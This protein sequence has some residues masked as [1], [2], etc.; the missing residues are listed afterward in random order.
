MTLTHR[1]ALDPNDRQETLL[2]QHAGW[3]RFAWNWGVAE[4]QRAL[5]AGEKSAT[6]QYRLRPAFNRIKRRTAPWSEA[7]SQN[8]AK[9]ALIDLEGAW[10]RFWREC[11]EAKRAGRR[12]RRQ[13]RPPRFHSRKRGM[14][15]RADNGPET[16]HCEGRTIHLPRIGTVRTRE[17]CRF[18]G[19]VRECTVKHDGIRWQAALVCEIADPELKVAGD[20]TGVDV[21]LRRLATLHDG[22][23][24]VTFDNPR[25]LKRALVK[26]RR[27]NRRIARSR[28]IHGLTRRSHRRERRYAQRQRLYRR[29]SNI[30]LDAIHKA[31]TA[32]AKRSRLVCIES[33]QVAGW[34]R[35]RQL[36]RATADASP[37]RFLLLLKWKCRR[38]GV[39]IV[40][41]GRFYPS[42]KT[43]SRCG[44]VCAHLRF[45]ETWRC[46]TC[47][48][49]H[50]RDDNAALNL[51]RQGLAVDVESVS[52]GRLAAVLH[53][54]STRQIIP[55]QAR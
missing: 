1:I 15:F 52:D 12:V 2:R 36:S 28:T 6:S 51:C 21:G 7:L 30:R 3:A 55:H 32:I 26:L 20:V 46:P 11:R 37:S 18:V 27:L 35:N 23:S 49:H 34:M 24:T 22:A 50:H 54:A 41:V 44:V 38:E 4:A 17:A 5:D 10:N 48:V 40:E 47:G 53:E 42:S 13:Y 16:V 33:L 14:A 39:R 9:Y 31:T 45:E 43:C 29:V 25:P 8:P 19:P